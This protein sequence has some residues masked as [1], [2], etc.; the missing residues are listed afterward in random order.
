[1]CRT[2]PLASIRYSA[3]HYTGSLQDKVTG[4]EQIRKKRKDQPE[5]DQ[6]AYPNRQAATICCVVGQ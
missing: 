6:A 1:M 2:V 4:S 3:G 5:T